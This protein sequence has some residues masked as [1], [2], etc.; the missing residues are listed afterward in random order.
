MTDSQD[1]AE[2]LAYVRQLADEAPPLT[3]EQAHL[4]VGIYSRY[5]R[6]DGDAT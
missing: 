6:D 2:L 3:A 5:P 1:R 4:L